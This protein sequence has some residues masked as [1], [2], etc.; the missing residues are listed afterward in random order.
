M[1]EH[2]AEIPFFLEDA[3]A[4]ARHFAESETEVR[5]AAFTRALD[6]LLGCDAAHQF[7]G[8]L[9]FERRALDAVQDAVY[10][11][12]RRRANA[13]VQVGGALGHHQLQQIR[14]GVRHNSNY[15]LQ[16]ANVESSIRKN[17]L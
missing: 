14:H 3:H 9:R 8:V 15:E 16:M 11:D 7:L 2:D 6:M 12:Y 5:A 4:E 13:D 1:P 17:S 10:A